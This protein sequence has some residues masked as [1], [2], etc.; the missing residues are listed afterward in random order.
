MPTPVALLHSCAVGLRGSSAVAGSHL[1][2]RAR[3]FAG[4]GSVF[5]VRSRRF[6]GRS[7]AAVV[8]MW[9]IA[10]NVALTPFCSCQQ[11]T[12]DAFGQPICAHHSDSGDGQTQHPAGPDGG[13]LCCQS[14]CT[15]LAVID[16]GPKLDLPL[17]VAWTRPALVAVQILLPRPTR[18]PAGPPRGPPFA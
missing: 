11:P 13:G 12:L 2:F 9:V 6:C 5:E 4:Y 15:S 7:I 14:C 17:V 8:A 1:V 18:H 3:G 16:T 10:L